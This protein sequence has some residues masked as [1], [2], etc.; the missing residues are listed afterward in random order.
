MFEVD[1]A[2]P[3]VQRKWGKEQARPTKNL[4]IDNLSC[5]PLMGAYSLVEAVGT[6]ISQTKR[7]AI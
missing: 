3:Q 1:R 7:S 5:T 2:R 6:I 4:V